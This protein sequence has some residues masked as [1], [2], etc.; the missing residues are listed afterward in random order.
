MRLTNSRKD[1][2]DETDLLALA[3]AL[4]PDAVMIQKPF[5][6]A[7]LARGIQR[8]LDAATTS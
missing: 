6:E 5:R 3:R 7:D 1:E 4:R 8:A 2:T